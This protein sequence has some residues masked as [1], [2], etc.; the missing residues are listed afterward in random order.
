MPISVEVPCIVVYQCLWPSAH[1]YWTR[2]GPDFPCAPF[3]PVADS[4]ILDPDHASQSSRLESRNED[5]ACSAQGRAQTVCAADR[6]GIAPWLPQARQRAG[7][8]VGAA[9]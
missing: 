8:V 4:N 6:A 2:I 5:G 9:L 7:Y 3:P 1:I